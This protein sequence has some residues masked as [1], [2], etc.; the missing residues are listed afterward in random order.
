MANRIVITPEST[1]S[2]CITE[3]VTATLVYEVTNY[4]EVKGMAIGKFI[5]SP[6]FR[7]G[8]Y[9]WEISQAKD[10][11]VKYTISM[12]E[13]KGQTKVCSFDGLQRSYNPAANC[14]GLDKFV[15]RSKLKSMSRLGDGCFTIRYVLTVSNES[16][17]MELP[18]DLERILRDGS[19]VDVRFCVGGQEFGAH[20]SVLAARS[21]V[22]RA[23]LVGPMA[24]KD[25]RCIK[26]VDLEPDIFD[27]MLRYIYTDSL[28]PC[29]DEGGYSTTVMQHMLVAADRYGIERLKQMCEEELCKRIDVETVIFTYAL[30]TQHQCN[31]LKDACTEF[32]SSKK[33]VLVAVLETNLFKKLFITSCQQ[34]SSKGEALGTKITCQEE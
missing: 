5:A 31:R 34:L 25:M 27:M 13:T 32:M 9:D 18:G 30:A 17:P 4:L 19:A 16:P 11:S 2:R 20:R 24:E 14:W 29:E 6:V 22:F 8:G 10:V 23:Q 7:V 15:E 3:H 1:S 21:P 28:P 26:V 12:V 33:E